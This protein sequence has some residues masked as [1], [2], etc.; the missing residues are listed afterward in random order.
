MTEW[1][2]HGAQSFLVRYRRTYVL[3]KIVCIREL[4]VCLSAVE[5][6]HSTWKDNMLQH[7]PSIHLSIYQTIHLSIYPSI[8][9]SIYSIYP[10]IHLSIYPS[11]YLFNIIL[12]FFIPFILQSVFFNWP[13]HFFMR[14]IWNHF[15][16]AFNN[17]KVCLKYIWVQ[18]NYLY[19]PN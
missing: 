4:E 15:R 19:A 1:R 17:S 6:K 2:N 7:Y 8:H 10:S 18:I 16:V 3:N 11:I 13:N 9:L 5:R 14:P 12:L